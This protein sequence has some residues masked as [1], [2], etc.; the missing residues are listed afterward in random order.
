MSP[1]A[2]WKS[3]HSLYVFCI[4]ISHK[5]MHKL[6]WKMRW[7]AQRRHIHLGH[8]P[9]IQNTQGGGMHWILRECN[10]I[11]SLL[12]INLVAIVRSGNAL[13]S[14]PNQQATKWIDRVKN[15]FKC[16]LATRCFSVL[17]AVIPSRWLFK[18]PHHM[19]GDVRRQKATWVKGR[20][21]SWPEWIEEDYLALS[22]APQC[23]CTSVD[24]LGRECLFKAGGDSICVQS[25]CITYPWDWRAADEKA[26]QDSSLNR[27]E[28]ISPSDWD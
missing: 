23:L 28:I 27:H 26:L 25:C 3:V 9:L 6:L 20:Q 22:I 1:S 8:W 11:L 5:R 19:C 15:R 24:G 18:V 12:P 17:K 4:I 16:F 10:L 21:W 7:V 13:G 2:C 14:S